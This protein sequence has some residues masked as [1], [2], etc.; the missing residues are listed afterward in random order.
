MTDIFSVGH[1]VVGSFRVI[2]KLDQPLMIALTISWEMVEL[3]TLETVHTRT[4]TQLY[5]TVR[6][7]DQHDVVQLEQETLFGR[8]SLTLKTIEQFAPGHQRSSWWDCMYVHMCVFQAIYYTRVCTWTN[9]VRAKEWYLAREGSAESR[10]LTISRLTFSVHCMH[11]MAGGEV[12]L[13]VY[14]HNHTLTPSPVTDPA[15]ILSLRYSLQ[16]S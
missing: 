16:Q 10:A 9:S 11:W 8:L 14:H 6:G 13:Y 2:L 4:H 12:P 5:I 15:D 3:A 1:D 7:A